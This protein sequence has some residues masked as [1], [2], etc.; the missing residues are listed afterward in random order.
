MLELGSVAE[1]R[2]FEKVPSVEGHGFGPVGGLARPDERLNRTQSTFN[3]SAERER[4]A[5]C[6]QDVLAK[7]RTQASTACGAAR[8]G[9]SLC[10][11]GPQQPGEG[12]PRDRSHPR[13]PDSRG[14]RWP[15]EC[16]PRRPRRSGGSRVARTSEPRCRRRRHRTSTKRHGSGKPRSLHRAA[17]VERELGHRPGELTNDVGRNDLATVGRSGDAG[18]GVHGLAEH[19]ARPARAPHPCSSRCAR[20]PAGRG[21]AGWRLRRRGRAGANRRRRGSRHPVTSL[22]GRCSSSTARRT[23]V[24]VGVENGPAP[25]RRPCRC[26]ARWSRRRR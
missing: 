8:P 17:V 7:C 20:R 21:R 3:A 11:L 1:R 9:P 10:R 6:V 23:I 13:R 15:C 19:V 5:I 24:A 16:R 25:P 12:V 4:V 2:A 14:R 18:R 22:L 26:A